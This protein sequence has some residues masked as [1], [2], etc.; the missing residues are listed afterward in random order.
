MRVI[1]TAGGTKEDIDP[2]RGITN[3]STGRL[4]S[5]IATR[6]IS[7]GATV[8]YI[9]GENAATPEAHPNLQIITIRNTNQLNNELVSSLTSQQYDAVIHTMAVSDYAPEVTHTTKISSDAPYI[10]L[11]LKRLPKVIKRIKEIQPN[12]KLVGTKLLVDA[13]EEEL[14]QAALK[15]MAESKSDYVLANS[16]K[17]IH[18]DR[19]KAYLFNSDGLVSKAET[20]QE[21]AEMIYE[22]LK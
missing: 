2:V 1:V 14:A 5:L 22:V 9:R 3:Y 10:Q 7:V 20:K 18:G 12:T 21:I 15:Q 6:F 19:H 16:L 13:N 17:D 8:T 4:G 11:T